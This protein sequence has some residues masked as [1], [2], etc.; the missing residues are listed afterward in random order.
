MSLVNLKKAI[1]LEAAFRAFWDRGDDIV[2]SSMGYDKVSTDLV[3][4]TYRTA[5]INNAA[6][7][8]ARHELM[9]LALGGGTGQSA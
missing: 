5:F 9:A 2:R 6:I 1:L 8:R 4:V 7:N 3:A